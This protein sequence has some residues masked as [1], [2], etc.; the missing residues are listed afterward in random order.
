MTD[1]TSQEALPVDTMNE[2]AWIRQSDLPECANV[3][4]VFRD[5]ARDWANDGKRV[6]ALTD[7]AAATAII[8]ALRAERDALRADAEQRHWVKWDGRYEK[9]HYDVWT[10]GFDV[11]LGCWPN[12][13][14]M[15]ATDGSDRRWFPADCLAVRVSE[16]QGEPPE[17]PKA[18]DSARKSEGA[19]NAD[20]AG[21]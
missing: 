17:P 15:N 2:L 13:G 9:Q 12:A 1:T 18:I 11:V 8:D 4:T 19:G 6:L 7:H 14:W 10:S 21:K 16:F 5:E 20:Q 3:V